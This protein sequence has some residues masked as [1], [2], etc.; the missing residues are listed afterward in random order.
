M[1]DWPNPL[2]SNA[3][4]PLYCAMATTIIYRLGAG[5]RPAGNSPGRLARRA[6]Q[7]HAC[8]GVA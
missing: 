7:R 2:S 4:I 8:R 3:P 1:Q 6:A 5:V